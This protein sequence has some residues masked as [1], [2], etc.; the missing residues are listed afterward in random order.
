MSGHVHG[1]CGLVLAA[2]AGSRF[3]GP[4]ALALDADGTPW[5]ALAVHMLVDAG[6]D[7]VFVALG[8]G[9]AEAA[10]LVPA[11]AETVL[12]ED[13]AMGLSAT[14]RAG[15]AAASRTPAEA[16]VITPVDTPSA[17]VSAVTRLLAAIGP[18]LSDGCAQ[19]T[20]FGRPGHPVIIGRRHWSALVETLTGDRGAR[21]Y[22]VDNGVLD[23]ECGDL[24]D[25][26]DVDAR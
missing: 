15:I 25:G 2:G 6:C 22:L 12:V 10:A 23:V 26:A 5:S 8:A 21:A 3:G 14:L 13:W 24:W 19:A 16:L 7:R 20:Y 11:H 18:S 4:K 17:P 9:S 1:L